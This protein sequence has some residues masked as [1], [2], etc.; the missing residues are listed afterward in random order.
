M[1]PRIT[2]ALAALAC[3]SAVTAA[4]FM[5]DDWASAACAAWN[6]TPALTNELGGA[7]WAANDAGRGFKIIQLYRSKCGAA[8][9]V[10]LEISNQDGKAH[11]V[12]GGAVKHSK[13]DPKV[14]Y[15]MYASDEDWACM[16][17]GSFGCGAMGAMMTGKLKFQGPKAE[18]MGVI[19][20]FDS[21]LL[22]AGKV[23]GDTSSCPQ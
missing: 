4:T 21:F 6:S 11:C 16:G 23:P 2:A 18:A 1:I 15:L 20:P 22:L 9:R 17:Q 14:D 10:E 8:S 13:L 12:R 19:G 3:S 7:A 5:D